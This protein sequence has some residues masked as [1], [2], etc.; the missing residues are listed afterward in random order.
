MT[1]SQR[2][3]AARAKAK[4]AR[5]RSDEPLPVKVQAA[6]FMPAT[7][8]PTDLN[9]RA[10]KLRA[11]C[12]SIGP[13]R[14]GTVQR[15]YTEMHGREGWRKLLTEMLTQDSNESTE[16]EL[17]T[18][19]IELGQA[20]QAQPDICVDWMRLGLA[21]MHV[22]VVADPATYGA[23]GG[24]YVDVNP[25]SP[26]LDTSVVG[27]DRPPMRAT[28]SPIQWHIELA[29]AR[30][31]VAANK[32]GPW[33]GESLRVRNDD[34]TTTELPVGPLRPEDVAC[35]NVWKAEP[36]IYN[37]ALADHRGVSDGQNVVDMMALHYILE[38]EDAE[39]LLEA[40]T[41]MGAL[42]S[43]HPYVPTPRPKKT[44]KPMSKPRTK[45]R[46]RWVKPAPLAHTPV[47]V[48]TSDSEDASDSDE[49]AESFRPEWPCP[50]TKARCKANGR[51]IES[52]WSVLDAKKKVQGQ[53]I[54]VVGG[55]GGPEWRE[56]EK[57]TRVDG[58]EYFDW[59]K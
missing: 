13:E 30:A 2:R 47:A 32:Y 41:R 31:N 1:R 25:N 17:S 45:P 43:M 55:K 10:R 50:H 39:T 16:A 53:S 34:F 56:A 11:L 24:R 18:T 12:M 38:G 46:R 36:I 22:L 20:L 40:A 4:S 6:L 37:N 57:K 35:F 14:R 54:V 21:G 7:Y 33:R 44:K 59:G 49:P 26:Y 23:H 52:T 9:K 15:K 28:T 29:R 58:T 51:G 48:I 8:H 42:R 5:T 19:Q 27:G 3:K